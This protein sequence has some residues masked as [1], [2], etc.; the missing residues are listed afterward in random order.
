MD[1]LEWIAGRRSWAQFL[2]HAHKFS[3]ISGTAYNTAL[4]LDPELAEQTAKAKLPKLKNPPLLG[5]TREMHLL[6]DIGDLIY[7]SNAAD[8]QKASLPRPLTAMDKLKKARRQAGLNR[9][10]ARFSPHHAHLTPQ[11]DT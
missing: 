2:R 5:W 6:T 9:V 8:P 7:K 1:A 4:L 10:V 3:L 11:V